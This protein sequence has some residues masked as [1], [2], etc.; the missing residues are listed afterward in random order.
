[1]SSPPRIASKPDPV[2]V[3]LV[4]D[5]IIL[6]EGLRALLDLEPD[7]EVVG[8]ADS[9]AQGRVVFEA[10]KPQLV[11]TDIALPGGSGL[12]IIPMLK[13]LMSSVR[14]LVLSAHCTDEYVRV[15]LELGADG[16]I[17]K[18]AS[19]SELLEGIRAINEGR[20]YFSSAVTNRVVA[21]FL[22]KR[23]PPSRSEGSVTPREKEI[24]K[25]IAMAYSTKAIASRL[26]LSVKTV[27]KHRSNLMRKLGLQNTAAVTM[28]AVR[29]NLVPV[30]LVGESEESGPRDSPP[31]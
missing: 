31:S 20:Q 22:G 2:R 6:R 30:D 8:E 14:V 27:E 4:E 21:G 15:A 11:I 19:R 7:L 10:L 5:H 1:L 24:L 16:Y 13:D 23:L 29:H 3:L 25:L 28:Y 9:V 17:L 18:D 26:K 12:A